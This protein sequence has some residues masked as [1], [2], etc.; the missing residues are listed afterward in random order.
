MQCGIILCCQ[1]TSRVC[2]VPILFETDM[3]FSLD[4]TKE[5]LLSSVT[6]TPKVVVSM[7]TTDDSQ[8]SD[9]AEVVL[10]S[11]SWL[12]FSAAFF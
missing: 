1:V 4:R 11:R 8:D 5:S 10:A 12:T 6:A 9:L 3:N 2:V 7:I